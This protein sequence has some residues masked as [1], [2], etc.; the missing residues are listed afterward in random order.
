LEGVTH[1]LSPARAA[2]RASEG[3]VRLAVVRAA[4]D[5][6]FGAR[7]DEARAQ[8]EV[9]V[10]SL[11]ALSPLGVLGRGYALVHDAR[12]RVVRSTDGARIGEELRVR[13]AEG[14]LRCR[15]EGVEGEN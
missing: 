11:D 12:G 3:R 2:T 5:A 10:A 7:L 4:L 15:V 13:L 1:R 6:N 14:A 9:A 8:L